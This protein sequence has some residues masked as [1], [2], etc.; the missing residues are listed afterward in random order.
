MVII[1]ATV[2][3]SGTSC[4]AKE[5]A[6]FVE[7]EVI[8]LPYPGGIDAKR[9]KQSYS[10]TVDL[11]KKR[12]AEEARD[13]DYQP[14]VG[15][16]AV[17]PVGDARPW[18]VFGAVT[19]RRGVFYAI[20]YGPYA[21]LE[22]YKN[23]RIEQLNG[24]INVCRMEIRWSQLPDGPIAPGHGWAGM[25]MSGA[26]CKPPPTAQLAML[27]EWKKKTA[28]YFVEG[29]ASDGKVSVA[30][31]REVQRKGPKY[32]P[33][34]PVAASAKMVDTGDLVK[35]AIPLLGDDL[36]ASV[37]AMRSGRLFT[38]F[39]DAIYGSDFPDL[40]CGVEGLQWSDIAAES[41]DS[42]GMSAARRLCRDITGKY[43]N[44][45]TEEALRAYEGNPNT[46]QSI[47]EKGEING[48]KR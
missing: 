1:S 37:V 17:Y 14:Q 40:M 48:E 38:Y 26:D 3:L 23:G 2:V 16:Y 11:L 42:S 45:R 34:D 27:A 33:F 28:D 13:A 6:D 10:D 12:A 47:P 36:T 46:I 41:T 30:L 31:I 7:R 18:V 35:W 9:L 20:P 8:T 5:P 21:S 39:S 4:A 25:Y 22:D 32:R 15:S 43:K 29:K 19:P 24:K 44:R